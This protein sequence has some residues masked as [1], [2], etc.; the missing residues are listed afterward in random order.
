MRGYIALSQSLSSQSLKKTPDFLQAESL[1]QVT[2]YQP[3]LHFYITKNLTNVK[4][5]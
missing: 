3:R 5:L 1:I 4:S 2:E